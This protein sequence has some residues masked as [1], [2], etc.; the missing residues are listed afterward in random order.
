MT[1]AESLVAPPVTMMQ[2]YVVIVPKTDIAAR[3]LTREQSDRI[4]AAVTSYMRAES[5][6]VEVRALFGHPPKHHPAE[7]RTCD[8]LCRGPVHTCRL[9][10]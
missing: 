10:A 2:S 8:C 3:P 4:L 9:L 1:T 6:R 5:E 7:T